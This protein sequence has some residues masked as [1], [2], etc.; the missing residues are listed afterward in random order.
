ML[1]FAKVIQVT[2]MES[3]KKSSSGHK[4]LTQKLKR[5]Y[6]LVVMDES[7][8]EEKIRFRITRWGII[9]LVSSIAI[10]LIVFTVY[11]IAFTSLREYIPGYTDT[12]L[13]KKIYDLQQKTDSLEREFKRK[14][15]YLSN[16]KR[17]IEGKDIPDDIHLPP[18]RGL[19]YDTI[20][21]SHS[22]A[23]SVLR[24]EFEAQSMYNLHQS[25]NYSP[26]PAN[27]G[28]INFFPPLRGIV[29][30][31]FD[32]GNNHFGVDIVASQN[33]AIKSTLNGTVIFSDWTLETGY[34][35]GIQHQNNIISIY[36]HNS[37]LLK[38][39]GTFVK[40]GETISIVG[41]SGELTTGPHLH[42]E[43][44]YNGNPIDPEEF[45]SF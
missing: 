18:R 20:P 35:I 33:E 21:N 2:P 25:R 13:P 10:V 5:R 43:L 39:E 6:K 8:F 9:V 4:S 38:H 45:I 22:K 15:I 16:L 26:I 31:G 14:D 44:W 1:I 37:A 27:F 19:N 7:S 28:N 29:T 40:A 34:I 30:R 23:D 41:E 32:A 12:T 42:F 3:K 24:A 17:I 36:K 11:L